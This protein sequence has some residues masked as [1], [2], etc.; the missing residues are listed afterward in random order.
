V[1]SEQL[2]R[3]TSFALALGLLCGCS[4]SP[5]GAPVRAAVSG[6][7][8]LDGQP[9]SKGIVRF[10]PVGDTAGPKASVEI[11]SGMFSI[12]AVHG[13]VVGRHR[14]EI[15]STD[16]GGIAWDDEAGIERIK[17]TKG[18]G[19]KMVRVPAAY[20]AS[21]TLEESVTESGPNAYRFALTTDKSR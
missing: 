11:A 21:S 15:D 1:R 16:D 19:L 20:N 2:S 12:D 9:L 6:I 10:V 8:T 4:R 18:A 7:V 5:D 13:P 14:I 17:Q 3:A